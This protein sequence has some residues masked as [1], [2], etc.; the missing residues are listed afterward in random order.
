M[1][2]G[3]MGGIAASLIGMAQ[4]AKSVRD[5]LARQAYYE[6]VWAKYP[7]SYHDAT[8]LVRGGEWSFLGT[9]LVG[10]GAT[11][12]LY[13]ITSMFV[14]KIMHGQHQAVMA[15]ILAWLISSIFYMAGSGVLASQGLHP[16]AIY[17]TNSVANI[18]SMNMACLIAACTPV[19]L[20]SL[21]GART[22]LWLR[23]W[24]E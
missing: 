18:T 14:A 10:F 17:D 15:A 2:Y 20:V 1:A 9:G 13:F 4:L 24:R 5:F 7:N 11:L 22:G 6:A 23:Q 8:N 16:F 19:V 21:L 12:L 3:L